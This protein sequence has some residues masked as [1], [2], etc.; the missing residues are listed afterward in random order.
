MTAVSRETS[1]NLGLRNDGIPETVHAAFAPLTDRAAA[2]AY[3]RQLTLSHYENFS[4]VSILL[5]KH[6]RQDFCNVYAFCR[7]ADDL[8]DEVGDPARSAQLLADFRQQTEA[9][10]AGTTH[11]AVF[12]ALRSTIEKHHIPPE[13]FLDLLS[14]F[15][16]DQILT[17]YD[18]FPQ[19]VDY[20]RRSADPVGRLVLYMCGYRDAH[21]QTLSDKT[22]TALQLANFWQ[23]VRRDL[24]E[25]DRI[26]LPA[27]DLQRFGVDETQL[28]TGAVTQ[29]YRD[30]IRF[31]V[32]RT[33]A[34]FDE[35]EALLPLL[36]PRY[37]GQIALFGKGG[38][39]V[40]AAIRRQNYD[41]LTRRPRLSRWQKGRLILSTLAAYLAGK[42]GRA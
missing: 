28:R 32:D 16:Q 24:L 4:V 1:D 6:L 35:G 22:C 29:N 17:R 7:V 8:G 42:A 37:R 10:Y 9:L 38:R 3:T 2:E 19:V 30:L 27:D 36:A 39:A 34:L 13:P 20:C 33:A 40:L 41:T 23:D 12:T 21:R 15:Q 5:P 18:N 25:R 31:Q 14:A 11:T 26:Y